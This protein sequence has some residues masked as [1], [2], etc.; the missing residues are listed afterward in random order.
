VAGCSAPPTRLE[1]PPLDAGPVAADAGEVRA[2]GE[3][4]LL[5]R[6]HLLD[7]V[8]GDRATAERLYRELASAA[9]PPTRARALARLRLAELHRERGDTR[10]ALAELDWVL[11][12]V[13]RF[14]DLARQ[15]EA[16]LVDV[17]HPQVGRQSALTRGPPV[18]VTS[19]EDV[20]AELEAQF[21]AAEKGVLDYVRVRLTFQ[22]HNVDA[23][24]GH[25]RA[26]LQAAEK[27]Y[28]PLLRSQ[29]PV[30]VAAARFRQG[31][32]HQ[33]F[34]EELGRARLPEAFL[35]AVAAPLRARIHRESG[36]HLRQAAEAY[37][38][39]M[40]VA[41][42]TAERWRREAATLEAQLARVLRRL[43]PAPLGQETRPGDAP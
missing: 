7:A 39:A 36:E 20:P 26:M 29:H 27:G 40:A 28:E 1:A 4:E 35:P 25:K 30:A 19:L 8:A 22:I 18:G 31:S 34:A 11:G 37:R 38:Q 17:L 9:G 23:V 33:D 21:R 41:D 14:P 3:A 12:R 6:A 32:L 42:V 16:V 10:A 13:K 2:D 43:P 24:L 15:A 5:A